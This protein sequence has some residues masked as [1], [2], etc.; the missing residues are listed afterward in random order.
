MQQAYSLPLASGSKDA[1][2][3]LVDKRVKTLNLIEH[4]KILL[5]RIQA[6]K[7]AALLALESMPAEA[8]N[9]LASEVK[10]KTPHRQAKVVS[11]ER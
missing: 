10:T 2:L 8:E 9:E 5:E 7:K 4:R 3:S 1:S 6:I 11:Q